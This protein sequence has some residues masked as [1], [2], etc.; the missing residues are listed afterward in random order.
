MRIY[1]LNKDT[2]LP[3]MRLVSKH[4]AKYCCKECCFKKEDKK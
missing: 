3:L 2:L 1:S 4:V